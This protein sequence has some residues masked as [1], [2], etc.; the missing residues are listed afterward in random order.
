MDPVVRLGTA[1]DIPALEWLQG[2][3]RNAL[4][5]VRG[6]NLRLAECA[7]VTDWPVLF[8]DPNAVVLVGELAGVVLGFLIMLLRSDIDRAVVTYAFVEEGARELGLGGTMVEQ[9]I[10]IARRRGVSGIEAVAL[11]GD[12][13]TKNLYERAGLTARKITV[14]KSLPP[15]G[16]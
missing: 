1:D 11:P 6:G 13:E 7:P 16:G 4:I 12:R 5:D 3:A 10:E 8:A 15:V 2:H 14:Y 9:A